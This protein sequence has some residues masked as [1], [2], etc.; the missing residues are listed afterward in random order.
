MREKKSERGWEQELDKSLNMKGA[1][2]SKKKGGERI[3][4]W[5]KGLRERKRRRDVQ[6]GGN[7]Y[8]ERRQSVYPHDQCLQIG[9]CTLPLIPLFCAPLSEWPLVICSLLDRALSLPL[10]AIK[11]MGP[12]ALWVSSWNALFWRKKKH[13]GTDRKKMGKS[14]GEM[15]KK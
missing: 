5:G 7:P 1:E 14:C 11:N 2:S 10:P 6:A 12:F 4:W 15:V 8:K 13:R 3:W 9:M